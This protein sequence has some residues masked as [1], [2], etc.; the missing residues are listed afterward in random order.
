VQQQF[1]RMVE[2]GRNRG[3]NI[4]IG[5]ARMDNTVTRTNDPFNEAQAE[6]LG[7]A[8]DN[9]KKLVVLERTGRNH[10]ILEPEKGLDSQV[11]ISAGQ[12]NEL[13]RGGT[14]KLANGTEVKGTQGDFVVLVSRSRARGETIYAREKDKKF[15][16][17]DQM[18]DKQTIEQFGNRVRGLY[19]GT[20]NSEGKAEGGTNFLK[21]IDK[22]LVVLGGREDQSFSEY[23]DIAEHH[24]TRV[25][26]EIAAKNRLELTQTFQQNYL[27]DLRMEIARDSTM[28]SKEKEQARQLLE[29]IETGLLKSNSIFR[30]Q[31]LEGRTVETTDHMQLTFKHM[32]DGLQGALGREG[33]LYK[34]LSKELQAKIDAE[35]HNVG[36]LKIEFARA[37]ESEARFEKGQEQRFEPFESQGLLK[38]RTPTDLARALGEV[39][40]TSHIPKF[41]PGFRPDGMLAI[42]R[43]TARG[44][45]EA[46]ENA[47][48]ETQ[49]V[50]RMAKQGAGSKTLSVHNTNPYAVVYNLAHPK[51]EKPENVT[52]QPGQILNLENNLVYNHDANLALST[53]S[54]LADQGYEHPGYNEDEPV[55]ILINVRSKKDEDSLTIAPIEGDQAF[56]LDDAPTFHVQ[57]SGGTTVLPTR[58]AIQLQRND[59]KRLTGEFQWQEV[60]DF[61]NGQMKMGSDGQPLMR[62]VPVTQTQIAQDMDL[63]GTILKKG[64]IIDG[65]QVYRGDADQRLIRVVVDQNDRSAVKYA[66]RAIKPTSDSDDADDK[67][68][69]E[70]LEVRDNKIYE[71][72]GRTVAVRP[73][74]SSTAALRAQLQGRVQ[75]GQKALA[76][77]DKKAAEARQEISTAHQELSQFNVAVASG[78]KQ[79][80]V[81]QARTQL[82]QD[83]RVRR[84][85]HAEAV[86]QHNQARTAQAEASVKAIEAIQQLDL[87]S[88]E[89]TP[90]LQQAVQVA[91]SFRRAQEERAMV[92]R[93]E[94]TQARYAQARAQNQTA[95]KDLAAAEKAS[96]RYSKAV[97]SGQIADRES[98][99]EYL[100][101]KYQTAVLRAN[102]TQKEEDVARGEFFQALAGKESSAAD[103]IASKSRIETALNAATDDVVALAERG[104]L[105]A[106]ANQL[107]VKNFEAVATAA[108][109]HL[110]LEQRVNVTSARHAQARA[111]NQAAQKDLAV[112]EKASE[113][114]S[115][116]VKL[117]QFAGRESQH[118]HLAENYQVAA[119]RANETQRAEDAAQQ[120]FL[121]ALAEQ[122]KESPARNNRLVDVPLA[123]RRVNVAQNIEGLVAEVAPLQQRTRTTN[124]VATR[125]GKHLSE[126]QGKKI[127]GI[128]AQRARLTE[129]LQ[130]AE[131]TA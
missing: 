49:V 73:S 36:D 76:V 45:S 113:G 11:E 4:F 120:D 19:E 114:Y 79:Q 94:T 107:S 57:S 24:L 10:L 12:F 112:A 78:Q 131:G 6:L 40:P 77:A 13:M 88:E 90:R 38:V 92:A 75:E 68:S 52:L 99:H 95:Q 91:Q 22:E 63:S 85:R 48:R 8:K 123:E 50:R 97:K 41:S 26:R 30:H 119:L 1:A 89:M 106:V 130:K 98:Q 42:E 69:Y 74:S 70:V 115:K 25:N 44:A 43:S 118:E 124:L 82:S 121:K 102:E 87:S 128:D 122:E 5:D 7:L 117:G 17:A 110:R 126:V 14:I 15:I 56:L 21:K 127:E 39:T 9:G 20:V 71:P 125:A 32:M 35:V 105:S 16:L 34:G 93:V 53:S 101:K 28:G 104:T 108:A 18:T 96:E 60:P 27:R 29:A 81:D 80:E 72:I 67:N 3:G 46:G 86:Q 51:A 100:A 109:T 116:A 54:S 31:N 84:D 129:R 65:V 64:D 103:I 33:D 66:M 2:E 61:E 83:R 62:R 47:G 37:P 111:Q 55:A 23:A 59:S 58:V